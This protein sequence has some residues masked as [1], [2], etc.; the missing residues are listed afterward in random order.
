MK[1]NFKQFLE[2]QEFSPIQRMRV[3][4]KSRH[5]RHAATKTPKKTDKKQDAESQSLNTSKPSKDENDNIQ[6]ISN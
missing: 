2:A 6:T 5:T 1:M 3:M 4:L